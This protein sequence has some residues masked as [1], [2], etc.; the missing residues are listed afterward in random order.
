MQVNHRQ[1]QVRSWEEPEC[2]K[3]TEH[4][5][6]QQGCLGVCVCAFIDIYICVSVV[7]LMCAENVFVYM[8]AW[9]LRV[10]KDIQHVIVRPCVC[11]CASVCLSFCLSVYVC[12]CAHVCVFV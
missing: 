9:V 2:E 11:V 7:C 10:C 5:I 3:R 8:C 4:I 1:R 6:Q 12:I